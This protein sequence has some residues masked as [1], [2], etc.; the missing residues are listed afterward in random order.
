VPTEARVLLHG[1]ANRGLG[2]AAWVCQQRPGSCCM[3]VLTEAWVLLHGCAN[4]G[5]GPD[6]CPPHLGKGL[7]ARPHFHASPRSGLM[8]HTGWRG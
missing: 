2:P 6:A 4:R 3:G 1:C 5:L 7:D 8:G